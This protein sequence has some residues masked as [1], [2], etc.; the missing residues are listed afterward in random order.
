MILTSKFFFRAVPVHPDPEFGFPDLGICFSEY[1]NPDQSVGLWKKF[2]L[3]KP[4]MGPI[5]CYWHILIQ[6]LLDRAPFIEIALCTKV[7]PDFRIRMN[8]DGS[9]NIFTF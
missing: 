8:R 4:Y 7:I 3:P 2:Y 6:P 9:E 5:F 1:S